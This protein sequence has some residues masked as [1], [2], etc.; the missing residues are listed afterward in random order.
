MA[1][2]LALN[3]GIGADLDLRAALEPEIKKALRVL[4]PRAIAQFVWH[5]A[6]GK[7]AA[8]AEEVELREYL[9]AAIEEGLALAPKWEERG[10]PSRTSDRDDRVVDFIIDRLMI[11][12]MNLTAAYAACA[13]EFSIHTDHVRKVWRKKAPAYARHRRSGSVKRQ[14]A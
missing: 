7:P 3:R 4:A 1:I 5:L 13:A 2:E 11:D 12:R 10:A 8:N 9:A 6:K 14:G